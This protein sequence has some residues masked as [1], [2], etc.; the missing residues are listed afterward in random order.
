M[1]TQKTHSS[2][3]PLPDGTP[4]HVK[5]SIKARDAFRLMLLGWLGSAWL[6]SCDDAGAKW[7]FQQPW[8]LTP[9]DINV[10][11]NEVVRNAAIPLANERWTDKPVGG[12]G[13]FFQNTYHYI[14]DTAKKHDSSWNLSY[15]IDTASTPST[16]IHVSIQVYDKSRDSTSD[17]TIEF[18]FIADN[19]GIPTVNPPTNLSTTGIANNLLWTHKFVRLWQNVYHEHNGKRWKTLTPQEFL[20]LMKKLNFK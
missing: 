3:T 18:N 16:T 8:L 5:W 2:S 10:F 15:D 17:Q 7:P 13:S 9:S 12:T 11:R 6:V 4:E 20:N 19:P 1:K 14:S